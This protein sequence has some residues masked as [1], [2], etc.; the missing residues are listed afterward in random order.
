MDDDDNIPA[1]PPSFQ[2]D[3]SFLNPDTARPTP[4]PFDP[5]RAPLLPSIGGDT[6]DAV[7]GERKTAAEKKAERQ[8]EEKAARAVRRY[9]KLDA[10]R[11]LGADGLPRLRRLSTK[12]KFKGRGHEYEDLQKLMAFYQIWAHRLFPKLQFNS[13]I[14]RAEKVCREK[15][16]RIFVGSMLQEDRRRHNLQMDMDMDMDTAA[17]EEEPSGQNAG[18]NARASTGSNRNDA[19]DADDDGNDGDEQDFSEDD[20]DTLGL[21]SAPS[22]TSNALTTSN[23][24]T[25]SNVAEGTSAAP[26]PVALPSPP[27]NTPSNIEGFALTGSESTSAETLARIAA[28]KER[29]LRIM[30]EKK[31]QREQE[32]AERERVRME[33]EAEILDMQEIERDAP[34]NGVVTEEK[35]ND[36][37]PLFPDD[38]VDF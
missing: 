7:S 8:A 36:D 19:E 12:M 35:P 30:A 4:W 14:T 9:V 21:F 23:A 18:E 1:L 34:T 3:Q 24:P 33:A 22:T 32:A 17:N 26:P 31:R 16:L 11:I 25:T 37:S 5:S 10:E 20:G 15:R 29:A 13:F 2:I 38:M 6:P 28:N 27:L